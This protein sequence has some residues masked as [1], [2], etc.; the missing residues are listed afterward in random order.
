M[1]GTEKSHKQQSGTFYLWPH[2]FAKLKEIAAQLGAI[3]PTGPKAGEPS[4]RT[5]IKE[6]ARGELEVVAPAD[7]EDD[8]MVSTGGMSQ[9]GEGN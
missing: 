1:E 7:T 8:A 9:Q 2:E 4:W 3:A 5:L 6:I